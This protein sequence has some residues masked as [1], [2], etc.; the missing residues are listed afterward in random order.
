M[1]A[2]PHSRLPLI[3]SPTHLRH[4]SRQ[5]PLYEL[6]TTQWCAHRL[7]ISG[8]RKLS[9]NPGVSISAAHTPPCP[10]LP[11][12]AVSRAFPDPLAYPF[13]QG[14]GAQISL[15]KASYRLLSRQWF[16]PSLAS[17][18]LSHGLLPYQP[19]PWLIVTL[20][21]ICDLRTRTKRN[22]PRLLA[23]SATY[24]TLR[25]GKVLSPIPNHRTTIMLSMRATHPS[26]MCYPFSSASG[27]LVAVEVNGSPI[28][29]DSAFWDS[30]TFRGPSM[31]RHMYDLPRAEKPRSFALPSWQS[32]AGFNTLGDSVLDPSELPERQLSPIGSRRSPHRPPLL[33]LA[34]VPQRTQARPLP[35]PPAVA[36]AQLNRSTHELPTRPSSAP[37]RI[38]RIASVARVQ[39]VEKI[40]EVLEPLEDIQDSQTTAAAK[41][42]HPPSE[43]QGDPLCATHRKRPAR[44]T[45][46]HKRTP[47]QLYEGR[48]KFG[49][50]LFLSCLE[51]QTDPRWI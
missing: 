43:C 47:F 5:L 35:Q 17:P 13:S 7:W 42:E 25:D 48:P 14:P 28:L 51:V 19:R 8:S 39:E 2:R 41:A 30:I 20:T 24:L 33:A 21:F 38:Q 40:V 12:A 3:S 1:A 27:P 9:T 31:N 50:V 16:L 4:S 36:Q 11:L 45:G 46:P 29:V 44:E 22:H 10:S 37:P 34:P 23:T 6:R 26:S 15:V 32:L 18:S 49:Y